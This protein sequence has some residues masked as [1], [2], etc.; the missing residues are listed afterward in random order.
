[1]RA[2]TRCTR[3]GSGF[4]RL[5]GRRSARLHSDRGDHRPFPDLPAPQ[6]VTAAIQKLA[7]GDYRVQ[8]ARNSRD[9]IGEIWQAM[10]VC[11]SAM[12]EAEQ[13]RTAQAQAEGQVAER[14][15]AEMQAL[16]QGF[17]ASVGGLVQHL[18]AAAQQME[19]TAQT[20]S[21]TAVQTHQQSRSVASAADETSAN[22]QAV[23][24]ATEE[25][26]ASASEIGSQVSQSSRIAAKAVE[27]AQPPTPGESL[28]RRRAADRR[29]GRADPRPSPARPTCWRST[30]P[31][32]RPA[33][34]RPGAASPWSPPR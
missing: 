23:A 14:R 12:A 4:R 8:Q 7:S 9:E 5:D 30:P 29:R 10:T 33:P 19:A 6:A 28:G 20:M 21:A 16:A 25:L 15:K 27:K 32:R 2:R 26:A 1:M 17:E 3:R 22:V 24:A 11:G 18:S 13:L 34:A 31:S